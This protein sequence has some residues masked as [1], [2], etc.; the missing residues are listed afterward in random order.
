MDTRI[1]GFSAGQNSTEQR[2]EVSVVKMQGAKAA[3]DKLSRDSEF[4]VA[5]CLSGHGRVTF[6][7]RR[8]EVESGTMWVKLP[9][10]LYSA[11]DFSHDF[12]SYEFVVTRSFMNGLE[13]SLKNVAAELAYVSK[14]PV[15]KCDEGSVRD[16]MNWVKLGE[17]LSENVSAHRLR[18]L[19][20]VIVSMIYFVS[21][22]VNMSRN[23]KM[24]LAEPEIDR[25][26]YYFMDFLGLLSQ[27]CATERSVRFYADKLFIT[28]KY[29]S[30][31]IKEVSGKT[32]GDWIEEFVV[33]EAKT[34]LQRTQN[35]VSEVAYK[36][37]FSSISFFGKYFKRHTGMSPGDYRRTS[38]AFA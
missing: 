3:G 33:V 7:E 34:M 2:P 29:L 27:H 37:N 20:S 18:T 5:V 4:R 22:I 24:D 21:D 13:F 38:P 32:A 1:L 19:R 11:D 12:T 25:K 36:L 6:N 26:Y 23:T 31:V 10:V 8:Y 16:F 28:P 17:G 14:M 35:S 30:S 15:Y 9:G